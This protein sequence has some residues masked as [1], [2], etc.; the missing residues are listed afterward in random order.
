[1]HAVC[2]GNTVAKSQTNFPELLRMNI[3][4]SKARYTCRKVLL[5]TMSG[6]NHL[7]PSMAQPNAQT[8]DLYRERFFLILESNFHKD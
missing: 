7:E 1:M 5:D 3:D 6:V 4:T 2:Q 8:A